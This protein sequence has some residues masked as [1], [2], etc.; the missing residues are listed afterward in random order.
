MGMLQA[1]ILKWVAMPS[2]RGSSQPKDQT[3]VSYIAGGFFTIRLARE[4]FLMLAFPYIYIR[5]NSTTYLTVMCACLLNRVRLFETLWA[6]AHQAPLFLGF[7]RQEDWVGL[8]FLLKGIFP[9]QKWNPGLLHILHL[10]GF[11]ITEPPGKTGT[12][13]L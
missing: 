10:D 4:A 3:Q 9:T 2:S 8:P 1:R 7:S 13:F 6:G 12:Q 11:F 5:G